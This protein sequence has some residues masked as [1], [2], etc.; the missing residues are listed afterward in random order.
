MIEKID[1]LRN[2]GQFDS[3]NPP[4]N[5][6]FTPFALIYAENGRGKTTLAAIMRSLATGD[7]ELIN[8]RQRLGSNHPPHIVVSHNGAQAVF[9]NGAWTQTIP[10]IAIFDDVFVATNVCSGIDLDTSHRQNLHELILGAQGVAL[11]TALQERVARIE[12]HNADLR[13]LGDSIPAAARAPLTVEAF[14]D[15][16]ADE[17]IDTKIQEAKRRLAAAKSA[18]AIRDRPGFLAVTL[19]DFDVEAINHVL[20]QT[21]PDL[22]S[23]A[24]T[25]V[26][27]HFASLGRGGEEWAAGGMPR[28][29]TASEGQD[30]EIC[31]FC[32]QD[33]GASALIGH[34]QSYFGETYQAL[35]SA[36]QQTSTGVLGAHG[37]DIPTAFER[38]I[39]TSAQ[40]CEFW[41]DFT[42]VPEVAVDTATIS[43]EWTAAREA[44]LETLRAKAA[45]PLE[46]I[47]LS[48]DTLEAIRLYRVRIAEIGDLSDSLIACNE[49]LDVV[50]EQAAA[51]DL[52]A[53]TDDLKKLEARKSRFDPAIAPHCDAYLAEK[54]AKNATEIE[55]GQARAAL[56]QYR[57][58]IFP[59]YETTMNEYLRRFNATFRVGQ[60]ESVN[61]RGGSSASYCVVINQQN[62]DITAEN[63]PSFRN[64][65]SSGDRNAL[66]L[67]FF[68]AALEQDPNLAQK[69]V[70]IDDPINS[71]DEHRSLNTIQ[72]MRALYPRVSQMIVLSHSKPFLCALWEGADTNNRSAIRISRAEIGSELVEWDVRN[73]SITLHDKHHELVSSYVQASDPAIE[74]SVAAALRPILEAFMRVA[75]PA[76]FPPGTLLGPFISLCKQRHGTQGQILSVED[77]DELSA[78][79][80]YANG[81]HHDTN[82]AW[83]T[84]AINDAEL[85]DF[86]ER[87]LLFSSRS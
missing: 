71:L 78:L 33:L 42:E 62:V 16:T 36:I 85:V 55:R 73:D 41:K 59:T 45:S 74:R 32:A 60:V 57:Q 21:L 47:A 58:N 4:N 29:A 24:A 30:T 61:L 27:A 84:E 79:R 75:C 12:Q 19:S 68:F 37:G 10:D 39:R 31:P 83:E 77:T 50:K 20:N 67:A 3:V 81:F 66:A 28:I 1:L 38:D 35:K 87:T 65:L 8:E 69:I 72:E 48:A 44:V 17:Q 40:N 2:I 11:N 54:A 56:D 46:A 13:A 15:L 9:Q 63:G 76:N 6:V 70:V 18:D 26:R 51:D 80:D 7:P 22:E 86:A 82:P 34:Y 64:T 25:R 43:R 23:D 53:L 52:A 5:I 14:C 49:R